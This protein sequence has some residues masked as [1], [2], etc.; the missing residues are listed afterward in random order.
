LRRQIIASEMPVLPEVGSR[1]VWPGEI[2]PD[3]SAAAIIE[4][5]TR[6]LT[7]PVGLA[8]SSFAN[9]FTSGF[10]ES[11]ES[12]TSGVLPIESTMSVKVPPQ[13]LFRRS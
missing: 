13:G 12:S 10:G 5:A 1:I 4:R 3:S 2:A 6:S 8:D 11:L 9:N 7:E